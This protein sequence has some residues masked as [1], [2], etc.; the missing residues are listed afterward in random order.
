MKVDIQLFGGRG[1][2]SNNA[3]KEKKKEELKAKLKEKNDKM[4]DFIEANQLGNG[5]LTRED[6]E[7][8][9]EMHQE[10]SN[11]KYELETK[12]YKTITEKNIKDDRLTTLEKNIYVQA[13][14]D[15]LKNKN[16]YDAVDKSAWGSHFNAN[17][18][19]DDILEGKNKKVSARQFYDAYKGTRNKLK[20]KYGDT[21]TLYRVEGKQMAKATKNYGSSIAYTRQYGSNVKSYK[22]KVKDIVAVNTNRR[23]T[24][25]DIIVAQGGIDKYLKKK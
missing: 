6:A 16:I 7:R 21:I 3:S 25:E 5:A 15:T 22:I 9:E 1:A 17:T 2:T 8:Y 20:K 11:L 23:G 19:V 10:I 24:Y 12:Y 13:R 18:P 4:N 14:K